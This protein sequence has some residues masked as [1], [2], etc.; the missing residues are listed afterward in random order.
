MKT[1]EYIKPMRDAGCAG[2]SHHLEKR[3]D[4]FIIYSIHFIWKGIK[5]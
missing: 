1:E 5:Y 2:H 3:L 4:E